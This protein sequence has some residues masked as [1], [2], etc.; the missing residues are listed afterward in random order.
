MPHKSDEMDGGDRVL[1]ATS[2]GIDFLRRSA[3]GEAVVFLHGIGS[4]G[5]SFLP[6]VPHLHPDLDLIFWNAPGYAGSA[7]L[8]EDWPTE[9]AYAA[10]LLRFLDA[11][12]IDRALLVGHSLGTLIAARFAAGHRARLSGLVLSECAA[13]YGIPVGSELPEKS[14]ARIDALQALGGVEFARTRAPKLVHEADTAPDAVAA[15]ETAMAAVT[16]P[17]YGQAVRMLSS[18]RLSESLASVT[19]PTTFVWAE[20]DTVTPEDQT[21]AALEARRSAGGPA[22]HYLQIPAAG[23]AVYL[24]QPE[25]FANIVTGALAAS[26]SGETA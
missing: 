14:R 20:G 12:G 3:P 9:D 6:L 22:P 2:A 25:A 4:R 17:G 13:G 23:H 1:R 8:A 26:A 18:G 5:E 10:A 19:I 16:L 11:L 24:Q 7:P 15:V 21:L